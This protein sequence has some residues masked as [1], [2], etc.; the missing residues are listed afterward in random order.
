MEVKAIILAMTSCGV[1]SAVGEKILLSFGKSELASFTNIAGLSGIGL[2]ALGLVYKL[3]QLLA[4][5]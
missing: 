4:S 3:F 1:I 2:S 5:L